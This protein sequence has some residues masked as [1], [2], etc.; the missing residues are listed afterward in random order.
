MISRE[1]PIKSNC[2]NVRCFSP[3]M[4]RGGREGLGLPIKSS[5]AC[6][7]KQ[8]PSNSPLSGG[9]RN[10]DYAIDLICVSLMELEIL[11]VPLI[12]HPTFPHPHPKPDESEPKCRSGSADAKVSFVGGQMGLLFA[13]AGAWWAKPTSR[14]TLLAKPAVCGSGCEVAIPAPDASQR[15]V[16]ATTRFVEKILSRFALS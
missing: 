14:D 7:Q 15:R 12:M 13:H 6:S 3:P 16:I 4:T 10:T 5:K 1:A 11:K 9:E 8:T 2:W